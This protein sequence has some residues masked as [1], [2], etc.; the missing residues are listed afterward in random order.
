MLLQMVNEICVI[1]S[2]N[3][4]KLGQACVAARNVFNFLRT[5]RCFGISM[6]VSILVKTNLLVD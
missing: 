1:I 4:L 2:S 3:F 6:K 5:D